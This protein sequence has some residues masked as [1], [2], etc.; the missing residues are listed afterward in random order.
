MYILHM[1]G[2]MY[3]GHQ[4]LCIPAVLCKSLYQL[5]VA[6]HPSRFVQ[7]FISVIIGC[8]SQP[9]LCKS[10]YQLSV[11]VHPSHFCAKVY[12]S[13]QW[14][15]IPAVFCAKFISVI[16]G[17]ASQPFFMQKFIL[18]VISGCASQPFLCKSLYQFS[19]AVHPSRF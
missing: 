8:A 17:C 4:W 7:K 11:A 18:S 6:V 5:S 19:V 14:L 2:Y 15:C 13:Y 16:S 3:I 12:I 1:W 10:L 9:F